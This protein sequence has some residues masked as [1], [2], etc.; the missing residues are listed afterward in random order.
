MSG[1]RRS[2]GNHGQ[3]LES[4]RFV[5]K[6]ISID[7]TPLLSS[8]PCGIARTTCSLIESLLRIDCDQEFSLFGRKLLGRGLR[9]TVPGI[10]GDHCRLPR[11]AESLMQRAGVVEWLCQADLYHAT[12]FYLPLSRPERAVATIHDLIFL[13]QPEGSVDHVRLARYAPDFARRCRRIIAVS[14]YTKRDI[15]ERLGIAPERIDIVYWGFDREMFRPARDYEA[16]AQ[17]LKSLLRFDGPYFLA[18]SC[19]TQRKNTPRML[20]AYAR[21]VRHNPRHHL[22]VVWDPPP[23]LR[24]EYSQGM[25]ASHIHFLPKQSESALRDLYCGATA[26]IYPSLYEGFGLPVLE[27]MACGTP[28]ITS[29]CSSLPEVGGDAAVYIDPH[30]VDSIL[31]AMQQFENDIISKNSLSEISLRQASQFSWERC[32][33]ETLAVYQKCLDD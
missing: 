25:L 33:R 18:V 29:Q 4:D 13:I 11:V 30:D 3:W 24:N 21:L 5:R 12:D 26:C 19:S 7:A 22:V 10:R 8:I 31:E 1:R 9:N 2:P 20:R 15:V 14:E 32:A 6:R 16:L 27:A 23:E 28:V 17:R